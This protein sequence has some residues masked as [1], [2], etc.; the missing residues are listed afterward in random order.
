MSRFEIGDGQYVVYAENEQQAMQI[1]VQ[2]LQRFE[3][4]KEM[5]S[6]LVKENGVAYRNFMENTSEENLNIHFNDATSLIYDDPENATIKGEVITRTANDGKFTYN[7]AYRYPDIDG[8]NADFRLAH[9]L[10]HLLLNP[11]ESSRQV[12]DKETDT[13]HVSGLIRITEDKEYYGLQIQENGINLLAQLAIRGNVKA[14]DIITGKADFSEF[15]KYKKCDDLVKLLAVSMRNDFDKEMTFEELVENKIDS[16]IE[17]SDGTKE[18]ANTFFYGILND[19]SIVEN[20]FDKYMGKGAWRELDS[21]IT[22]LHKMDTRDPK[23]ENVFKATQG[24]ITEFANVRMQEKHKEAISRNGDNIPSLDNKRNLINQLN[25]IEEKQE[26]IETKENKNSFIQRIARRIQNNNFLM[27]VPFV[28]KFVDR[29]LNVLPPATTHREI[30]LSEQRQ[31][32]LNR[33]TN[34]GLYTMQQPQRISNPT[35]IEAMR[36]KMEQEKENDDERGF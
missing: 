24:L 26:E 4:I 9:E 12:Y 33:L 7:L 19:S 34:D 36:R 3:K 18:P 29:Q 28:K 35:R 14:D 8:H 16:F 2:E 20:E 1:V 23:Y 30:P 6:K 32:F 11:S 10:G 25:G 17:H 22:E 27:N 21:A 13:T 5:M 15:N 31:S